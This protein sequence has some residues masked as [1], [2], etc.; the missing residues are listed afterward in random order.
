MNKLAELYA[1]SASP[2]DYIRKYAARLGALMD[3]LDL[4][5]VEQVI[6]AMERTSRAGNVIYTMANG[7]SAASAS[8]LVNDLVAGC[9]LEGAPPFRAFSLTDNGETVT[10]LANDCGYDNIF[11]YQLRANVQPGDLIIAMSVSGNSENIFRAVEYAREHGATTV[12][13]CGFDGGRLA[14]ACDIAVLIPTTRDEYGPVEDVF[15]ILGHML[16]TYLCMRRGKMLHH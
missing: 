2:Q 9:H 6:E 13:F 12:G 5:A 15:A 16:M 10:A 7:G 4:D 11:A 14:K 8:H 3:A 1:E